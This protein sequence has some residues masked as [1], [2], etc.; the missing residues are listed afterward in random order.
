MIIAMVLDKTFR[1]EVDNKMIVKSGI[2]NV[3]KIKQSNDN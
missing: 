1:K 2:E 3:F